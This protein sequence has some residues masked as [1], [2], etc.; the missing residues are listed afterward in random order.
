MEYIVVLILCLCGYGIWYLG[1]VEVDLDKPPTESQYKDVI[2]D[3]E[4]EWTR[5]KH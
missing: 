3:A 2:K 1:K 4:Q 5:K